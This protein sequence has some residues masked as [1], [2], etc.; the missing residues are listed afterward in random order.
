[1]NE[2]TERSV[3]VVK[4]FKCS[5]SKRKNDVLKYIEL[6]EVQPDDDW[7]DFMFYRTDMVI[8][9][10]EANQQDHVT[11]VKEVYAR[12]CHND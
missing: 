6:H 5:D 12:L 3:S 11:Y 1:M 7:T 4:S 10:F 8:L 2:K 9:L